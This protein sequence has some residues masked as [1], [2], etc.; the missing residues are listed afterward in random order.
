MIIMKTMIDVAR[1][2]GVS[3]TTVSRVV[4]GDSRVAE[5]TVQAVTRA[6]R[7]L[8]YETRARRKKRGHTVFKRT[9]SHN[10]V[11]VVLL[12]TSMDVHPAMAMAKLR[13]VEAAVSRAGL[14]VALTRAQKDGEIPPTLLRPDLCGALLWGSTIS[15]ELA[16][17]IKHLPH[18]WLSSYSAEENNV[19]LVGNEQAGRIAADYLLDQ[20]IERP[21]AICPV[22]SNP[23]YK[24]RIDGFHYACHI[25]NSPAIIIRPATSMADELSD[26]QMSQIPSLIEQLV[27]MAPIPDGLFIPDDSLTVLVYQA[28]AEHG[29]KPEQDI[30]IVSCDNESTYLNALHP[31]PATIDL[32]PEAT[33]RLAVEQLIRKLEIPNENGQVSVLINPRLIPGE[34]WS[35]PVDS[36]T[37][38]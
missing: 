11:A 22:S 8:G 6:M 12:D 1:L 23:Q 19:V 2:A 33:G 38:T 20:G 9:F 18:L 27:S 25:R 14:T 31:R 4:N 32:E 36:A 3:Q 34:R 30:R 15:L 24:L 7:E 17:Q 29:I 35:I 13:G 37:G 26:P 21:A 5:A 16:R 28:L 10:V